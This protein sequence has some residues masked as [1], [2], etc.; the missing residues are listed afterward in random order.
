MPD[1][2]FDMQTIAYV[3]FLLQAQCGWEAPRRP[4]DREHRPDREIPSESMHT[5]TIIP[6]LLCRT[7][8]R[9]R[10]ASPPGREVGG[11]GSAVW[12]GDAVVLEDSGGDVTGMFTRGAEL[13]VAHAVDQGC[14]VAALTDGSPSCGSTY[15]Y[16]GSFSGGTMEGMGVT[17]QLL[18]DN[19]IPVFSEHQLGLADEILRSPA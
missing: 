17:A 15:V 7:R 16:D 14:V 8:C 6:E 1:V 19:G 3:I 11:D 10:G 9:V 2:T 12:V 13:A 5:A 4:T 18:V